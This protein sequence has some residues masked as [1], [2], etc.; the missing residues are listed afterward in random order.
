VIAAG[1]DR[2]DGSPQVRPSARPSSRPAKVERETRAPQPTKDIFADDAFS[3]DDDG[4][5]DFD[6]P[7]FLK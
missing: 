3:F 4:E 5:D 7:S 1:F 2:F 6:V